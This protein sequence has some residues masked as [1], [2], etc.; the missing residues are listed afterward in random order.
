M[1]RYDYRCATCDDTFE[2][3]RSMTDDSPVRC[4]DGHADVKRLLS[5]FASVG[6]SSGSDAAP[7][8]APS[9]GGGCCGGAC[10]CG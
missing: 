5:V 1:P 8:S 4:P 6:A 9:M 10:G 2:V 3:R 7:M